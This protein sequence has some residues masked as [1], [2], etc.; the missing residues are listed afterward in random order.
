MTVD[1]L[2]T[3]DRGHEKSVVNGPN[4]IFNNGS[5]RL[6]VAAKKSV[7]YGPNGILNNGRKLIYTP[8][9]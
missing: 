2:R 5:E 6:R 4:G 3:P 9:F 7:V 8:F 1:W